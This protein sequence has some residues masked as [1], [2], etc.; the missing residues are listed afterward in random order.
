ML[1]IPSTY[2]M[3]GSWYI[4]IP[5]LCLVSSIATQIITMKLNKTPMQGCMMFMILAMPLFSAYI[6]YSVPA[7]VGF[8]W[9][10]STLLGLVQSIVMHR[11]Y[12]PVTMIAN[13]EARHVALLEQNE[14]NM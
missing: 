10:C 13:Q 3:F 9:I 8:Y 11:F 12:N 6:A 1:E 5:I 2:G 7:A 4:I 14:K